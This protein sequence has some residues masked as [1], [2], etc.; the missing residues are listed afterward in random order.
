ML[1]RDASV[2]EDIVWAIVQRDVPALRRQVNSLL[3]EFDSP[4]ES[5]NRGPVTR[6][7]RNILGGASRPRTGRPTECP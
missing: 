1:P 2:A 4:P 5:P 7:R 3:D 6:S